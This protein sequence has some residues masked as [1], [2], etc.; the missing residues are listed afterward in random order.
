MIPATGVIYALRNLRGKGP[1]IG[2]YLTLTG[3]TLTGA[4]AVMFGVATH[5]VPAVH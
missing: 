1:A 4:E 2:L 3:A 5:L